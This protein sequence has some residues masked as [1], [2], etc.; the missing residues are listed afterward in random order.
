MTGAELPHELVVRDAE[1][2]FALLDAPVLGAD[3]IK[4]FHQ[5]GLR[6]EQYALP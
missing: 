1:L 3:H 2:L 4:E 6:V 5:K